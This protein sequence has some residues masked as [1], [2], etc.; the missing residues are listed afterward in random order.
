MQTPHNNSAPECAGG[1]GFYGSAA[2]DGYCSVCYKQRLEAASST[3]KTPTPATAPAPAATP[4]GESTEESAPTEQN[5]PATDTSLSTQPAAV[6]QRTA[7][8][9]TQPAAVNQSDKT[10][11]YQCNKRVGLLGFKCRCGAICCRPHLHAEE[12]NCTFDYQSLNK[13]VLEIRN[14]KVITEKLD[15]F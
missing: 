5:R 12:H 3:G 14:P 9:T 6:T 10:R 11:C 4:V 2:T 1:C 7:D 8:P 15:R 13:Q